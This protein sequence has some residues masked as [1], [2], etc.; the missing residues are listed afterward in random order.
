VVLASQLRIG[1]VIRHQEHA[2]KIVGAEYHPGQGKMGGVTHSRVQNLDTGTLWEHSFRADLR[3]EEILLEKQT[4]EYSYTDGD[5]CYFMNGESFAQH[6]VAKALVGSRA[7]LLEPGMK[8]LVEFVEGKV[9][10]VVF[11]DVLEVKIVETAPAAHHQ[12]DV[13]CSRRSSRTASK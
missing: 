13:L 3:F 1:V 2:Y 6:E 9:V 12:Q 10:S 5:D 4:L 7:E 11:P 8:V